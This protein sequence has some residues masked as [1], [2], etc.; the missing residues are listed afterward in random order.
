MYIIQEIQEQISQVFEKLVFYLL[1]FLMLLSVAYVFFQW[2]H[3]KGDRDAVS[4]LIK[5]IHILAEKQ[6]VLG[7]VQRSRKE[8]FVPVVREFADYVSLQ[9]RDIFSPFRLKEDFKPSTHLPLVLMN[10]IK[11]QIP[12]RWMGRIYSEQSGEMLA[13]LNIH[14]ET[15]FVRVGDEVNGY[16]VEQINPVFVSVRD[17]KEDK[18]YHLEL[19]KQML[20]EDVKARVFDQETGE[21]I[22]VRKSDMIRGYKVDKITEE[23]VVLSN[24]LN[25]AVYVKKEQ[26]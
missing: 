23:Y 11:I 1:M 10:M 13:Q 9:E 8:L 19:Y 4:V 3:L 24:S 7:D 15:L 20:K 25:Q 5:K 16:R 18:V 22:I 21:F 26:G 6:D 14:E 12:L 2:V 17:L